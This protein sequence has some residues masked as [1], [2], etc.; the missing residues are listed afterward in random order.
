MCALARLPG[1]DHAVRVK[2]RLH[3]YVR[4]L[5][6]RNGNRGAAEGAWRRDAVVEVRIELVALVRLGEEVLAAEGV[7]AVLALD[8]EEVYE[9]AR[10]RG[11]LGADGEEP[12]GVVLIEAMVSN[13]QHL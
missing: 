6:R 10:R 3:L 8:R 12:R 11:A 7:A 5:P 9:H 13:L 2:V 1:Q 4:V